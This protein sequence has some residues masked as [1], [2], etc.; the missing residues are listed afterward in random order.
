MDNR[1]RQYWL[2]VTHPEYYESVGLSGGWSCHKDTKKGDLIFL[3]RAKGKSDIGFLLQAETDAAPDP[4]WDNACDYKTIYE[5]K[6]P[7]NIKD[8][9]NIDT[10]FRDWP[11]YTGNFQSKAWKIPLKHWEKL[12]QIAIEKDPDYQKI[13]KNVDPAGSFEEVSDHPKL[14]E[15]YSLDALCQ[16]TFLDKEFWEEVQLLV[17][18]K[19]QIIFYGPPGTG[20]T[21][22]A[23]EFAKYWVNPANP[24]DNVHVVQFHPSYAYEEFVEGIRPESNKAPDGHQELSYPVKKG[25]F[26]HLCDEAQ[27][28]PDQRYVLIMDEINRGE[29]P[30][31]MG[32][33]LYL[34]EYRKESVILPYSGS[35][36]QIPDNLFLVGTMNT[37]DRSIALLDHALRRRFHFIKVIARPSI[38][39]DYFQ[40]NGHPE[41]V[42]TEKLLERLNSKLEQ[43][44]TE[45][46]LHIG[47]SHFMRSDLDNKKLNIIWEHSIMP[48]LEEYFYQQR[49]KLK[50]YELD[51]LRANL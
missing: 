17:N 23:L 24:H 19:R 14:D 50:S 25:V 9:R 48:T 51:A 13:I 43:D 8:L 18:D 38:L 37:A 4:N 47:H 16:K 39:R 5:F 28:H 7:V 22:I 40:A 36:F 6:N 44:G 29:L 32:E 49:D 41:M 3:W 1:T 42:W 2:W 26:R 30:R 31:I 10:Y 35:S 12:N 11:A 27:S 20:K 15:D 45:W 33:L 21:F 46:D 34:L